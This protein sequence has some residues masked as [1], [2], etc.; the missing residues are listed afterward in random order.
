MP[1]I[2]K[3]ELKDKDYDYLLNFQKKGQAFVREVK[4]G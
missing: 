2:I 1:K 4:K 3:F